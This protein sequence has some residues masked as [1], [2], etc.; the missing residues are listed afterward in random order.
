M[1]YNNILDNIKTGFLSGINPTYLDLSRNRIRYLDNSVFRLQGQ[2]ETLIL[3]ENVLQSLE[4]GIFSDC[5][6]L[7]SLFLC[8][9][10]IS[11][12]SRSGFVRLEHLEPLDISNNHIEGFSP[13]VFELFFNQ[14]YCP[15]AWTNVTECKFKPS[16][17][18]GC[19]INGAGCFCCRTVAA[20]PASY[21]KFQQLACITHNSSFDI[22]FAV[23]QVQLKHPVALLVYLLATFLHHCSFI[24]SIWST[25][26]AKSNEQLTGFDAVLF[27][28]L[29]STLLLLPN[30]YSKRLTQHYSRYT[31]V[32]NTV[33]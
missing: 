22:L 3:S 10:M 14:V 20:C 28:L 2:L 31:E 17:L 12:I 24:S 13:L 5:T 16:G 27:V 6:N 25:N 23:S 15:N 8:A 21:C 18:A 26:N 33:W 1:Q 32:K 9:N 11:D 29:N 4:P 19:R 7:R 30:Y